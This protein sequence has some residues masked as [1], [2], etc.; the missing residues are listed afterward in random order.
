MVRCFV[1]SA[2]RVLIKI[3]LS[4]F[5]NNAEKAMRPPENEIPFSVRVF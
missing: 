4:R 2:L 3:T 1:V 5:E